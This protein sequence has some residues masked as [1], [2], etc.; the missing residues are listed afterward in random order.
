MTVKQLIEK[1]EKVKD[2][3][4][5]LTLNID[6]EIDD[7]GSAVNYDPMLNQWLFDI[8]EISTGTSGYEEEGEVQLIGQV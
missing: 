2:K 7:N 4:L 8:Y 1:L 5:S 6:V 3:E